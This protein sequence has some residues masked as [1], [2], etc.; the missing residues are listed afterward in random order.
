LSRTRAFRF[1]ERFRGDHIPLSEVD[2]NPDIVRFYEFGMGT[3]IPELR[4]LA[5]Y[6]VLEYYFVS[7]ANEKLHEKMSNRI[8][9]PR[10]GLTSSNLDRLV[11]D[12]IEHRHETDET[13][14][15]KN[16]LSK[17]VD[18]TLLIDFIKAYEK[19]LGESIYS[20][21]HMVFGVPVEV[22]LEE[23]HVFGNVAKHIK[24]IRN[25][26]VHSTDRYERQARH[27]PFTKTTEKIA[28]DIPLMKFLAE[29]VIIS[30]AK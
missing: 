17:F 29:R 6:Q 7:T 18:E 21:R 1:T 13:K 5:F 14:M 9:D 26:L 15:L 23:G 27:V 10:F 20:K 12:V 2:F 25:A 8:K 19:H 30:S 22:K 3:D 4:F 28:Q 11:H 16:V 24:E